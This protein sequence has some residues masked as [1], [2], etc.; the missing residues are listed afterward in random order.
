MYKVNFTQL[1]HIIYDASNLPALLIIAL[2]SNLN[3][4]RLFHLTLIIIHV[5]E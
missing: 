3:S 1:K 5:L 4:N 2:L